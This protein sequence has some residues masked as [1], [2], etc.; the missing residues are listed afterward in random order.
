MAGAISA[1]EFCYNETTK[2]GKT[3]YEKSTEELGLELQHTHPA[4]IGTYLKENKNEMIDEGRCFMAYMNAKFKEK[5]ILKQQVLLRADIPQKYG[6]K[7]LS[8]EKITRQRDI[9]LRIC[10]AAKF[11][12]Q[13]TQ[14]ALELYRMNLLYPRVAR[15][16]LLMS[17]FS[18]RPGN[19]IELNETLLKNKMEPLRSSGIQN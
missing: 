11:T 1:F 13:E 3:M 19:I 4:Y 16:A 17:C 5:K 10:Y 8:E 12:L 15:D 14:H 6:Y 18:H 7:I 2:T 9:I